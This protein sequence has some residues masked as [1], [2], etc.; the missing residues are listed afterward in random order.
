[1]MNMLWNRWSIGLLQSRLVNFLKTP[2]LLLLLERTLA[3]VVR[4]V[5]LCGLLV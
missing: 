1:M 4:S 3:S 5:F 2:L